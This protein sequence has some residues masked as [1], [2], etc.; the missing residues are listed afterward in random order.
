MSCKLSAIVAVC[1][2]W[3][4]GYEGGMIVS[5][6]AD[7]RRFVD[8]TSSH[9]VIMGRKTLESLPGGRP[10]KNR[11]NIVLTRDKAFSREGIE[12]VHS[13]DDALRAIEG[14]E[15]AWVIGGAE[16]Y[17]L[18]LP[19][20]TRVA[21]TKNHCRRLADSYFVNLDEMDGWCIADTS[22]TFTIASEE[23]DH[24]ITYEFVDYVRADADDDETPIEMPRETENGSEDDDSEP[25]HVKTM[26]LYRSKHHGNTKKVVDAIV[27]AFPRDV[28]AV[29]VAS[30]DKN[31]TV[32]LSEYPLVGVA[33]GI[34]YGEIDKDLARVLQNSLIEGT[35]VFSLLTYGGASKW[36]GKDIDGICRA[37]R[38]NYLA[39]HGCV[40]Y[41]TWGP[42]KLTGGMNKGRPDGS[43]LEDMVSWYRDLVQG[44]GEPLNA[45]L[46]KRR[47][48]E[49]W[50]AAH[51]DPTIL[52]KLKH[53]GRKLF[54][55]TGK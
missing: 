34:Y 20:C 54:R 42:Y 9:T 52:D 43:D 18:F 2:D 7:M 49:A 1:D 46:V 19:Y 53:T 44:Y 45:E 32:D 38:A 50:N 4:I 10:L 14:D 26:I 6:R 35:F 22:E 24:G 51:P 36:Y 3:G 25:V 21:V 17:E 13:L 31:Q 28:D 11:R 40:G 23:E 48:R 41:D 27:S 8:L 37:Q 29:D 16:I 30:L 55:R 33:S 39:G 12:V 15:E 47:R 5:N